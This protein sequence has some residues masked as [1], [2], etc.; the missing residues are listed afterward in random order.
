MFLNSVI[1][2]PLKI[3]YTLVSFYLPFVL[4]TSWSL[5]LFFLFDSFVY[6]RFVVWSNDSPVSQVLSHPSGNLFFLVVIDFPVFPYHQS[7]LTTIGS[8]EKPLS[9]PSSLKY[10]SLHLPCPSLR[11][12]P[13]VLY[14]SKLLGFFLL[15]N[16]FCLVWI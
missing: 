2:L 13:L 9:V 1:L 14:Y 3:S 15:W 5:T 11:D 16:S 8:G 12:Y 4:E 6:I 10:R 7:S